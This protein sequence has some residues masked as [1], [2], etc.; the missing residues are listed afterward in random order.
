[1]AFED[2]FGQ[3]MEATGCDTLIQASIAVLRPVF[4]FVN[5][6]K[7]LLPLETDVWLSLAVDPQSIE[8]FPS[9]IGDIS[10]PAIDDRLD[11]TNA[12]LVR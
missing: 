12:T 11:D 8:D 3:H 10:D 6:S 5:Q 1:M 2:K 7:A 9:H 4:D